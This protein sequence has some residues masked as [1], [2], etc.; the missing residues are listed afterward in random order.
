MAN[1]VLALDFGATSGW[2][3]MTG[4]TLVASG[5][6][7]LTGAGIGEKCKCYEDF[8]YKK[9][10]EYPQINKI[11]FEDIVF[12]KKN[13]KNHFG[14][15]WGIIHKITWLKSIP[16]Y[17]VAPDVIKSY[18]T[19]KRRA[20]KQDMIKAVNEQGYRVED[21]NEADAIALALYANREN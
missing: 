2:A 6:Y 12:A 5:Y 13:W 21:D 8:I 17:G 15:Y 7:D 14:M 9:L 4:K 16:L 10:D 3:V 18:L 11:Y 1:F 19:C 20:N